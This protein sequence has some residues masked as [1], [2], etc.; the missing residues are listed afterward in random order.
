M[1]AKARNFLPSI[2]WTAVILVLTLLPGNYIPRVGSFWNLFSPDKL[3]HIFLFSVF[4]LL[5]FSGFFK[6]YPGRSKRYITGM[7]LAFSI[8]LAI[9]TELLQA[10][11]PLGRSGNVYDTIADFAGI[12]LGWLIFFQYRKKKQ[13]KLPAD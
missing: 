6:Q 3:I 10:M 7:V 4:A 12:S 1:P 13:K 2:I 5:L 8:L 11:L 9:I